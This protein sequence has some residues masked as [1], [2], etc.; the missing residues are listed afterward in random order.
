MGELLAVAAILGAVLG[1]Q[2][3]VGA[4]VLVLAALVIGGVGFGL[5]LLDIYAAA[6]LIQV[7]YIVSSGLVFMMPHFH[8]TRTVA[9][10]E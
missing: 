8:R 7:G 6:S 3:P 1:D 2:S 4:L 5:S 9:K 10:E